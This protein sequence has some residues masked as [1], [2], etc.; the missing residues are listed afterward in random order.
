MSLSAFVPKIF[1]KK[2]AIFLLK[3]KVAKIQFFGE[4]ETGEGK[5]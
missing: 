4:Q 3:I 5:R 2:F 1:V